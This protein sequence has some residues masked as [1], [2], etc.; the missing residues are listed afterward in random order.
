MS[1]GGSV[2]AMLLSLRNNSALAS[3]TKGVN[4]LKEQL[5]NASSPQRALY[6]NEVDPQKLKR[7]QK[8][9]IERFRAERRRNNLIIGSIFILLLAFLV[10]SVWSLLFVSAPHKEMDITLQHQ[11]DQ[12]NEIAKTNRL[13][14]F[15]EDGYKWL[16]KNNFTNA[17]YQFEL[18]VN[19]FPNSH[20]AHIGLIK[21]LLKQCEI[22]KVNCEKA[23]DERDRLRAKI[24]NTQ[25]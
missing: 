21:A 7:I 15:I 1:Y 17:I 4:R 24:E 10:G 9:I 19:E 20:D 13:N 12:E 16:D 23:R 8:E 5:N 3:K 25:S 11:I 18:A 14:F 2:A 6:Q 22:E